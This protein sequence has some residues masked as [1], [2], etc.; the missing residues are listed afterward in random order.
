MNPVQG[1]FYLSL[2][3]LIAVAVMFYFSQAGSDASGV[4]W[5][6][7][8]GF[9]AGSLVFALISRRKQSGPQKTA[10]TAKPRRGRK[11]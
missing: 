11:G 10:A 4:P 7:I 3:A 2:V 1:N 6:L 8:A 5:L 9:V